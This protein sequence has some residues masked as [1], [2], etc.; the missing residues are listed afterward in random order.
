MKKV[1]RSEFLD[2]IPDLIKESHGDVTMYY[3][4]SGKL[5]AVDVNGEYYTN[6]EKAKAF[7]SEVT[8]DT[9]RRV[10]ERKC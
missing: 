8:F 6:E 2:F 10:Y 4:F 3:N 9:M 5:I 1:N 7:Y